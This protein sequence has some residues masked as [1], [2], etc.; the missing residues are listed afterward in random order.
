MRY[1]FDIWNGL[2][3]KLHNK[4]ILL[5]LDY[6]GTLAPI[7]PTPDKAVLPKKVKELLRGLVKFKG[8][9]IGIVSGR[10]LK[11]IKKMVGVEGI[12]YVGNHG[13]EIDGPKIKFESPVSPRYRTILDNIKDDLNAKLSGIKGAFVEDKGLSLSVHYRLV[14]EKFIQLAKT[15]IHEIAIIYLV[16]NKIRIKHG[17]KVIEIRPPVAWDKGKV[18]LWLLGREMFSLKEK[19]V[20]PIYIGDDI[21]DEDAFKALKKT[22]MTIF[23]GKPKESFAQYYLKDTEEVWELL[24]KISELLSKRQ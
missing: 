17:K 20:L 12:I 21:S 16:R 3:P 4:D 1:L 5:L 9:K 14:N 10:A 23:I 6:D 11:N 7:A 18:A 19:E 15:I 8:I 22:G 13:L 24:C 2:E